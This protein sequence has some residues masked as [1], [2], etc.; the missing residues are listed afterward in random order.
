MAAMVWGALGLVVTSVSYGVGTVLQAVAARRSDRSAGVDARLFVSLLSQLPYLVGLLI[1]L[2]GFIASLVALRT[3]PLFLVQAAVASS[4]GVTALVSVW[5]LGAR[6]RAPELAALGGMGLGLVLLGVSAKP[7]AGKPLS[8]TGGWLLLAMVAVTL[9]VG[10]AVA[11]LPDRWASAGLAATAGAAWGGLGIAA[12]GLVVPH[13]L[14]HMV[15]EPAAWAIAG[16]GIVAMLLFAMS[17]QRGSATS[18]AAAA[19]C[20]ETLLPAVVGLV[21]LGDSARDGLALLAV[22]AFVLTV[23]G[24]VALARFAEPEPQLAPAGD[25]KQ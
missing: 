3:L 21:F 23:G 18:S 22:A 14:W 4:V 12:R 16:N 8:A 6:L 13:P 1:E 17:L 9:A 24:A 2:L 25:V 15:S 7:G 11:R 5:F 19:L 10:V 20:V